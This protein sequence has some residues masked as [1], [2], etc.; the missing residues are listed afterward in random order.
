[1]KKVMLRE[2][3][4]INSWSFSGPVLS[5]LLCSLR[6]ARGLICMID[7]QTVQVFECLL[8]IYRFCAFCQNTS[9]K[10]RHIQER[11]LVA[12]MLYSFSRD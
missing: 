12:A 3:M 6:A 1:M 8:L 11:W 5:T 4:L 7:C 2:V 9:K 10:A